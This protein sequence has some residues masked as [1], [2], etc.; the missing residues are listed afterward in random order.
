[1]RLLLDTSVLIWCLEGNETRLGVAVAAAVRDPR[2]SV[3]VSS[4]TPW[5][6]A[7]KLSLRRLNI[8]PNLAAWLSQELDNSGFALLPI[9]LEHAVRVE[10]L[11]R[12]HNDPFDRLLI[13]QAEIEGLTLVT[14]D[15]QLAAYNPRAIWC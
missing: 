6:M 11:P 3:F 9:Q 14:G 4:V 13:A 8:R 12:H 15:R 1:M 7:I 2:N 10:H 5:E